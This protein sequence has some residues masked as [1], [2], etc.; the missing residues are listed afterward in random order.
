[1]EWNEQTQGA[2]RV[3]ISSLTA[4]KEHPLDDAR[5]YQFIAQVWRVRQGLWDEAL[6]RERMKVAAQELHPDWPEDLVNKIVETR[7]QQGT[8]ILDF[9]SSL[10]EHGKLLSLTPK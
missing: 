9:L 3:W 4:H 2:L 10:R 5:F 6:A 7:R 1:M 8:L